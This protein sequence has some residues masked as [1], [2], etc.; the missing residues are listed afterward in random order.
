MR[1]TVD[2]A[3]TPPY[4][5]EP[6]IRP[7]YLRRYLVGAWIAWTALV[8][9][10]AGLNVQNERDTTIQLAAAEARASFNKD[11]VYRRWAT[12]HGGVYVPITE[13]TPPN[14]FL[15]VPNRDVTTES[16]IRMTLIN[17]AYMMRQVFQISTGQY[18]TRG[19]ITAP[20]PLNPQ[21]AADSWEAI[22][23]ERFAAGETEIHE[24]AMLG[25]ERYM[26]LMQPF[27]IEPGCRR[28]HNE[29][30]GSLRGGISISVPMRFYD[31]LYRAFARRTLLLHGTIG[32]F[33]WLGIFATGRA[34]QRQLENWA[35][36][37]AEIQRSEAELRRTS[38]ALAISETR[39]RIVAE[40]ISDMITEFDADGRILYAND[41]CQDMLGYSPAEL[42]GKHSS[43]F[44]HPDDR[45][46]AMTLLYDLARTPG[47]RISHTLRLLRRDGTAIWAD[48]DGVC[49]ALPGEKPRVYVASRDITEQRR[50]QESLLASSRLAAVGSLASGVA[51]EFNNLLTIQKNNAT[52]LLLD[53]ERH[54]LSDA[55]ARCLQAIVE[56]ADRGAEIVRSLG[57][58][59][60]PKPPAQAAFDLVA[61]LEHLLRVQQRTL[62]FNHILVRRRWAT[63]CLGAYADKGQVEQV[64]INVLQNAVHA[65]IPKEGGTL[66]IETSKEETTVRVAISDTGVGMDEATRARIFDPFFTTK[67]SHAEDALGIPGTG[68]GLAISQKLVLENGGRIEVT[69]ANGSG[70][71]VTIVLPAAP[72][73]GPCAAEPPPVVE[74]GPAIENKLELMIIEDDDAQRD[75]LA[76]LLAHLGFDR[77]AAF[78]RGQDA[79]AAARRAP[80]RIV[81]LDYV[82]PEMNGRELMREMSR[83][84]PGIRF[85][86]LTGTLEPAFDPELEPDAILAKPIDFTDLARCLKRIESSPGRASS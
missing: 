57:G 52:L 3:A 73:G 25:A 56:S 79:L 84:D 65:M 49:T 7:G 6:L 48:C 83:I 8:V 62:E 15:T 64:L 61:L 76:E 47:K 21:N 44:M 53:R 63:P 39:H 11:V 37:S 42:V 24:I 23:L 10:S 67:G 5:L 2:P 80:P 33:G 50:S 31:E 13:T 1:V 4:T 81:L 45:D 85:I 9:V 74:S 70:T 51:H 55:A 32:L 75:S 30:V 12:M 43:P 41:R 66:T 22:A 69:S 77:P 78:A 82:M 40:N 59:A 29:A 16:G 60:L 86:V 54:P 34:M 35:Q 19:H 26:R 14:P 27:W 20:H 72:G 58:I 68:L 38:E 17:P 28:C 36:A 71:T 46:A 18:G